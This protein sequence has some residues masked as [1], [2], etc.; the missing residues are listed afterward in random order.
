[1]EDHEPEVF[2]MYFPDW[3][4]SFEGADTENADLVDGLSKSTQ[5]DT[6]ALFSP[7]RV[8]VDTKDLA[9]VEETMAHFNC[10]LVNMT[11]FVFKDGKF[12][13]TSMEDKSEFF[14][15]DSYIF[16]CVYKTEDEAR[17]TVGSF[18]CCWRVSFFNHLL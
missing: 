17:K 7:P 10:L 18:Q 8:S 3:E 1:M 14:L 5:M 15:D 16:L 2:K 12:K 9:L 6:K 4:G 13:T 11:S